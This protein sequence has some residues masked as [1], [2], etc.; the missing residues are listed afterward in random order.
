MRDEIG[1]HLPARFGSLRRVELLAVQEDG[2]C[3][4][5]DAVSLLVGRRAFLV[6]VRVVFER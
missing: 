6:G 4:Q 1:Q 2:P 5:D 3:Q